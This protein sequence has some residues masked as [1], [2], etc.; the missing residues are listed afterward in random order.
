MSETRVLMR[1][2]LKLS[3]VLNQRLIRRFAYSFANLPFEPRIFMVL[4]SDKYRFSRK[5]FVNKNV[6]LIHCKALFIKQ[7]FP[8]F[9]NPVNPSLDFSLLSKNSSSSS[10]SETFSQ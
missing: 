10:D 6:L 1:Y 9:C 2:G 5:Y 7:V 3:L 4:I 8:R